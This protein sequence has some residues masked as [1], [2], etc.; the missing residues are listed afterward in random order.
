MHK[1]SMSFKEPDVNANLVLRKC[2][3]TDLISL[4]MDNDL[5]LG[6]M[7]VEHEI[8]ACRLISSVMES[9]SHNLTQNLDRPH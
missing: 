6:H 1:E 2:T 7:V 8:H 4:H 3:M 5:C 9:L